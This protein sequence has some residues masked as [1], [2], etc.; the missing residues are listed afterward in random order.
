MQLLQSR[1]YKGSLGSNHKGVLVAVWQSA[2]LVIGR[3]QNLGQ[4]YFAP[5]STLPSVRGR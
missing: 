1:V 2:G 3:L 4:G 5:K